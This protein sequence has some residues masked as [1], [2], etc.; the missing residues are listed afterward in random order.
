MAPDA[1]AVRPVA[2]LDGCTVEW[3]E[4]GRVLLSRRERLYQAADPG[5][6][7]TEVGRFPAPLWKRALTRLRPAQRALR[8]MFYNVLPLPDGSLFVTFGRQV[9]VMKDGVLRPLDGVERPF[10]VLRG[11]CAL[12]DDGCVYFGEYHLNPERAPVAVYRYRP[13]ESRVEVA[14]R[15]TAGAVRH[16]HGV[17]RDPFGGALWC[18]SG[19]VGGECRV[20]RTA[21]GFRSLDIVGTGD[22]SW[23]AV[24]IQF[25]RD[26]VYYAM[27]AEFT[28]NFIFRIDRA[29]GARE[30][31]AAVEGP[32]YYSASAGGRLYFAVSAELCPSQQGDFAALWEVGDGV[33]PRRVATFRKDRLGVRHFMPGTLDF[34]A[35]PGLP[36][37][38]LFRTT[39]L[40]GDNRTWQYEPG[41][42]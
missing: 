37:R 2:G 11:G 4:P 33:K 36:G 42:V 10:R 13:G 22:E 16:V 25:Q 24:S 34:P 15:F 26:A 39:A 28:Q 27:D 5:A 41:E 21:D 19:D 1:G 9:A 8:F 18:L 17:F 31:V 40:E 20:M 12:A 29:T 3:A 38:L 32:V 35:G 7:R 14:H 23:R 30:Q 6:P